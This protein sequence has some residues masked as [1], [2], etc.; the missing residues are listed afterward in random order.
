MLG[1]HL[2]LDK[3]EAVVGADK[4]GCAVFND[5]TRQG[6]VSALS[7]DRVKGNPANGKALPYN[8]RNVYRL[9]I[10]IM[11]AD[12]CPLFNH[13]FWQESHANLGLED[14]AF[15]QLGSDRKVIEIVN[16]PSVF[17]LRQEGQ[18]DS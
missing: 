9:E 14:T 11:Q 8:R 5:Q 10:E 2:L 6:A 13:L 7:R 17:F 15:Q 18:R 12:G 3:L 4:F 16:G 1:P